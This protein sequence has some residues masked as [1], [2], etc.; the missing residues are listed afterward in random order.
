MIDIADLIGVPYKTGGRGDGGYDC[1][2]LVMEVAKRGGHLFPDWHFLLQGE[3]QDTDKTVS[4]MTGQK[5][6][7]CKEKGVPRDDSE[8]IKGLADYALKIDALEAGCIV[9]MLVLGQPHLGVYLGGGNIIHC[10]KTGVHITKLARYGKRIQGYWRL[11][12]G[13]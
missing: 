6:Y 2:G 4:N 3:R 5:D 1:Y 12:R 7:P 9:E 8:V 11:T 13:V 10:D